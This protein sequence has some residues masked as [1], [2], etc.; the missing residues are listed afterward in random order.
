MVVIDRRRFLVLGAGALVACGGGGSGRS[1]RSG[2]TPPR[3]SPAPAPPQRAPLPPEPRPAQLSSPL[4]VRRYTGP[5]DAT[6]YEVLRFMDLVGLDLSGYELVGNRP[7]I[8]PGFDGE[9]GHGLFLSGVEDSRLGSIL[10][11]EMMGDGVT[12]GAK[13]PSGEIGRSCRNL[14]L[15]DIRVEGARRNGISFIGAEDVSIERFEVRDVRSDLKRG[16]CA[17]VD[18]EP[19]PKAPGNRR[20]LIRDGVVE[21]CQNFGIIAAGHDNQDVLIE[22]VTVRAELD[23]WALWLDFPGGTNVVR[24]STI[25]GPCAHLRNV[26]FENCRFVRDRA[27]TQFGSHVASRHENVTFDAACTYETT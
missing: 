2:R 10:V 4:D 1:G 19:D 8:G 18:L 25:Y 23:G 21:G 5:A 9:W 12:V 22:R 20:I 24:D 6:H 27:Y 17:G 3:P 14:L 15:Q 26:R 16:P 11:R 13:Y 7:E